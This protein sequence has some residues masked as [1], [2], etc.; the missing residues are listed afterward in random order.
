[1]DEVEAQ[2]VLLRVRLRL[3]KDP[4]Q[5]RLVR[6]EEVRLKRDEHLASL[7]DTKGEGKFESIIAMLHEAEAVLR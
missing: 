2:P 4:L 3:V 7:T 1:M 5:L 6:R